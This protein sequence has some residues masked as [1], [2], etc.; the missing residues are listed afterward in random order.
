V[1]VCTSPPRAGSY[2]GTSF[3][4][5]CDGGL[6]ARAFALEFDEIVCTR[7]GGGEVTEIER[8]LMWVCLFGEPK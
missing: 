8:E 3:E 4:A 2:R 6:F 7:G 1:V 5:R